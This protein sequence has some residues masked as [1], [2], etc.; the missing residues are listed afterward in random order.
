MTTEN[1]TVKYYVGDLCYVMD[2]AWSEVC[3]LIPFDNS[4]HEFE[5]KD[6]RKFILFGTA[7]GDGSYSDFAGN[8]YGVDS[9]TIGAVKVDDIRDLEGLAKVKEGGL[10]HIHDFP[11]DFTSYDCNFSDGVINIYNVSIDT[12]SFDCEMSDEDES[13]EDF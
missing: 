9:G 11:C 7:Y 5:L 12:G 1:N 8:S 6:G 13:E 10:G 4:E 2:D 3:D